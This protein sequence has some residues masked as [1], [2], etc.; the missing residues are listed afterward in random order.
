MKLRLRGDSLRLRLTQSEVLALR[1]QGFWQD[2]TAL[3]PAGGPS[4]AYRVESTDS[5]AP[6]VFFTKGDQ[7]VVTIRIP[8]A[9][10][11]P[12][13]QSTQVGIYFSETWGLKVAVEKD[14][15]CLDPSRDEDETD[16]FTNPNEG[17]G[18]AHLDACD[19]D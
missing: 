6:E 14:F 16:N 17:Q 10:I 1:D 8:S 15:R 5:A 18:H 3:G 4:L 12:W 19:A 13:S 7:A 9:E 2:T 11:A